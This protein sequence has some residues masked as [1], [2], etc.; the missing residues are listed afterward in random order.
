MCVA[1]KELEGIDLISVAS[2]DLA[3]LLVERRRSDRLGLDDPHTPGN[4]DGYQNKGVAGKGIRKNMKT[5][6]TASADRDVICGPRKR[7]WAG[8]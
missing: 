7:D 1:T 8:Y 4:A 3:G 5:K 6:G 2:K